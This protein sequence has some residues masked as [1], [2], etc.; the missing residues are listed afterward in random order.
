MDGLEWDL[1][2][3]H[4]DVRSNMGDHPTVHMD[5]RRHD[6]LV[7][8]GTKEE[9]ARPATRGRL[10]EGGHPRARRHHPVG[11]RALKHR[12]EARA[13][14]V[15]RASRPRARVELALHARVADQRH[16]QRSVAALR[17]ITRLGV[18]IEGTV[19]A[20]RGTTG[21]QNGSSV[22]STPRS[23]LNRSTLASLVYAAPVASLPR[24]S[25]T[26]RPNGTIDAPAAKTKGERPMPQRK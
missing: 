19:R 24:T 11:D 1:V 22:R 3:L 14:G 26:L 4:R 21:R 12:G 9:V 10:L 15:A 13:I 23:A 17:L 16:A 7:G 8:A 2:R 18:Q 25:C 20:R 6:A 5:R